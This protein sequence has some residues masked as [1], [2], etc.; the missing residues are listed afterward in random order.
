VIRIVV[1]DAPGR[2]LADLPDVQTVE[3]EDYLLDPRFSELRRATVFNLCRTYRYQTEGYYVSLLAA[4]RGHRPLPSVAT[5]QDLRLSPLVRIVSE[6]LEDLIQRSLSQLHSDRFELSIYFGRNLAERY[7]RLARALFNQFP[8]PLLRASFRR[9][10]RWELSAMRAIATSEVPESHRDFVVEQARR[11]FERP[12]RTPAPREYRYDLAIL[13][14]DAEEDRPSNEAALRK[15][16]R[17][18]ESLGI[19]AELVGRED[20]GRIAE[21][22]ALFLRETTRVN[23]HTYRFARR[24]AA[25]GLVVIDDPESILRCTNKVYQ[26]ELFARHKIPCPPTMVVHAE[27]AREVLARIGVPCVL[28]QPDGSFSRGVV[29]VESEAELPGRLAPLL[30]DSEL[31]LAQRFVAS[32]LDW[33]I[34][35]L[36]G[37]ALYACRYHMPRGEWRIAST[38]ASGRRRYGRV[39]AVALAEAPQGVVELAERAARLIGDGL[40]GVDAKVVEGRPMLIE[41]NDNPNLDAGCEDAVLRDELYLAIMR[42]F[43]ARLDARGA[44]GGS[45]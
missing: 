37:K 34:G 31:V 6:D 45:A 29:R 35:V 28:K 15:F 3:A 1:V 41:V 8:A 38:D 13:A 40:Y 2:W 10:G 21:F 14:N 17:A 20:Y 11:H 25:E 36:G 22:D 30:A 12:H 19:E 44:P 27:N 26:A 43:R 5:L 4:A 9:D 24:A 32:D 23:H 39:E 42:H 7:E 16:V 18:A 33:R